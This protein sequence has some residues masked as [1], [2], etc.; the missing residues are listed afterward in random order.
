[1]GAFNRFLAEHDC[2]RC[3][4]RVTFAYQFKFGDKHQYD[5]RAGAVLRWGGNEEGDRG[6]PLV[7]AECTPEACPAC[8]YDPDSSAFRL[9]IEHDRLISVEGPVELDEPIFGSM[10]SEP[11]TRAVLR[12]RR[13][14]LG[15]WSSSFPRR[16][17]SSGQQAYSNS[18]ET[19]IVFRNQASLLLNPAFTGLSW[20]G[21]AL[22][23][24]LGTTRTESLTRLL[25][26]M[27]LL[28]R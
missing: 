17:R 24:V 10:L 27:T 4:T 18:G 12:A 25:A 26:P 15:L 6:Q 8:G 28:T 2:P 21:P 7:L 1:M 11:D 14:Q 5:Y 9:R 3:R 22:V 23:W 16:S 19:F 13:A 20:K